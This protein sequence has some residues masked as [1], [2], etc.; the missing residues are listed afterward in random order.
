MTFSFS[1]CAKTFKASQK[2]VNLRSKQNEWY[3]LPY[4][5][6]IFW[7]FIEWK[8]MKEDG[9]VIV[10]LIYFFYIFLDFNLSSNYFLHNPIITRFL[11]SK[12]LKNKENMR[13]CLKR[14]SNYCDKEIST[15]IKLS[16]G[17]KSNFTYYA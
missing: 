1:L 10:I 11:E 3:I 13:F 17:K 9:Q 4:L 5:F 14:T 12:K 8:I 16:R 15:H 7:Y 2:N 6:M